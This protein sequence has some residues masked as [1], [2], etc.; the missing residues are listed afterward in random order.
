LIY[1]PATSASVWVARTKVGC[2]AGYP[3]VGQPVDDEDRRG[4]IGVH[5]YL[6][7]IQ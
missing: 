4:L 3:F 2:L 6:A 7:V 1:G 5:R